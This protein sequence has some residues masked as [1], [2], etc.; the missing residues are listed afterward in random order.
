MIFLNVSGLAYQRKDSGMKIGMMLMEINL[1]QDRRKGSAMMD[2]GELFKEVLYL[3]GVGEGEAWDVGDEVD[4][5]WGVRFPNLFC[6]S[7]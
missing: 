1:I 3:W 6:F 2:E 4:K 7:A 5:G